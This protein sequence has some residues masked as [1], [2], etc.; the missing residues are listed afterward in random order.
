M[1]G[2]TISVKLD[3]PGYLPGEVVTGKVFVTLQ[4]A[5]QCNAMTMKVR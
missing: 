4:E 3:K 1:G 2:S 5:I